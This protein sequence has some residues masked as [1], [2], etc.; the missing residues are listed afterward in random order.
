MDLLRKDKI[1]IQSADIGHITRRDVLAA[2]AVKEKDRY[3]GVILGF[4]V[5]VL[6]EAEREASERGIK[7]FNEKNH[8]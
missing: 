6:D 4:N 1:P 2:S 7:V 3:I 5:R 8:L